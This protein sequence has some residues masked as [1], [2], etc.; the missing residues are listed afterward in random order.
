MKSE[1]QYKL[2][3]FDVSTPK[4]PRLSRFT[5][6]KFEKIFRNKL[7]QAKLVLWG[8]VPMIVLVTI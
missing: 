5:D 6:F 4:L 3:L 1:P 7:T 2:F 8:H